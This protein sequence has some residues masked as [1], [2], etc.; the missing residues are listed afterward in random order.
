MMEKMRGNN[1]NN[2]KGEELGDESDFRWYLETMAVFSLS[3]VVT[4]AIT[5]LEEDKSCVQ[6]K[7]DELTNDKEALG[8]VRW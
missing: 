6:R 1:Y 2:N 5:G 3:G 4:T 7:K 8:T